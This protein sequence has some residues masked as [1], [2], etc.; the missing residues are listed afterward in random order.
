[1]SEIDFKYHLLKYKFNYENINLFCYRFELLDYDIE[2]IVSF[3]DCKG[4]LLPLIQVRSYR[5]F[6]LNYYQSFKKALRK[7]ER[8]VNEGK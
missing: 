2:I 8:L 1:M 5:N 6:T 4:K 7:I 3:N